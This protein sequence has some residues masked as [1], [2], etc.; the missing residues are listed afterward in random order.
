MS[1]IQKEKQLIYDLLR[2]LIDERRELNKQYEELKQ[3]LDNLNSMEQ[4]SAEIL[5]GNKK[6]ISVLEK[7]KTL[8][9][10]YLFRKNK[11]QHYVSFDRVSKNILSILKQS[12]VP[13]SNQQ[14]LKK[15]NTEYELC[16]SYKNLTCNILPKMLKERSL[17][18]ERAYRGY[19]QYHLPKL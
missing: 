5:S 9:K 18:I 13:L 12:P 2:K 16:I 6:N 7:E 19:W 14:L 10:D 1:D 17:P 11:T 15:I 4:V 8:S 3:R